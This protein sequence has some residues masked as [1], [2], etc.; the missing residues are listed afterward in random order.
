MRRGGGSGKTTPGRA[1]AVNAAILRMAHC[2]RYWA[3]CAE[4]RYHRVSAQIVN[5]NLETYTW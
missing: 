3:R 4:G 5:F 2:L 1:E